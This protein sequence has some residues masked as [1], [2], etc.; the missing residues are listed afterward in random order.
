[1]RGRGPPAEV[2]HLDF[3]H[4]N[5][6]VFILLVVHLCGGKRCLLPAVLADA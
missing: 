4:L 1:L 2:S 6:V 5:A 3:G